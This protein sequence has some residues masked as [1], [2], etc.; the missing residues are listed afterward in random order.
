MAKEKTVCIACGETGG[1][2]R[3]L[4][5]GDWVHIG[6]CAPAGTPR[7]GTHANWPLTTTHISG[8]PMVLENLGQLRAAER[9]YGVSS[10]VYN[11]DA[12]NRNE[13]AY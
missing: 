3:F 2:F 13:Q 4:A 6:R 5:T 10:E 8:E 1:K 7:H 11:M 12:G 9:S